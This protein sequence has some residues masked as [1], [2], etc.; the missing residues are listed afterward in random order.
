MTNCCFTSDIILEAKHSIRLSLPLIAVELIYTINNFIAIVMIA[1]LGKEQLAANVLV[2]SFYTA[3]VVFFKGVFCSTSVMIAQSFGIKDNCAIETCFKQSLIMAVIFSFPM[4]LIVHIASA[5]FP[6][7]QQKP[8]VVLLAKTFFDS[9]VWTILP[10]NIIIV[11]QQFFIGIMKTS[12]AMVMSISMLPLQIFLYYC[13]LFGKLGMP[14]MGLAGIGYSHT[15]SYW[16]ISIVSCGYLATSERLNKYYLFKKWWQI[17]YKFL[18]ELLR[19]GF[20]LGAMWCSEVAFFAVIAIIMGKISV[21][22]LAAFQI[23]SQYLT[24]AMVILFALSKNAAIRVSNELGHNNR[25]KLK[26]TV[27]INL[28]LGFGMVSIFSF[29]YIFFP[30]IAIAVDTRYNFEH[31]ILVAEKATKL[32]PAV[33]LFLLIDSLRSVINGGLRGLKDSNIQMLINSLGFWLISLPLSYMLAFKVGFGGIGIF[34]GINIGFLITGAL[35]AVRLNTLI[36]KADL[37]AI[38]TKS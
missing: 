25:I 5:A 7:A 19:I 36:G 31:Y 29:F 32:F 23:V 18:I 3:I 15:V 6:L 24:L 26:T 35:L 4:M 30:H 10:F 37:L 38:I 11:I 16:I 21:D 13:F 17:K 20:P 9:L 28:I 2:W 12:Y 8:E 33:G 34:W 22:D 1:H 27:I 14:E